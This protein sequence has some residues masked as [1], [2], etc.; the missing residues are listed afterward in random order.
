MRELL[1]TIILFAL[2]LISLTCAVVS[3]ITHSRAKNEQQAAKS[4]LMFSVFLGLSL[5]FII[6]LAIF[7]TFGLS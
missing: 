5:L 1:H 6:L 4:S 7:N 2:F 3:A